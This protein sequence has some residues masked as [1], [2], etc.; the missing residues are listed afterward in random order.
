LSNNTPLN[1]LYEKIKKLNPEEILLCDI[2][3]FFIKQDKY[4][5]KDEIIKYYYLAINKSSRKCKGLLY[6][7]LG[8]Y[9]KSIKDY[10][11]MLYYFNRAFLYG[12]YYNS[13]E[14]CYFLY[15]DKCYEMFAKYIKQFDN[16][17][18]L[19]IKL[20]K[21]KYMI[22]KKQR[23]VLNEL[24]TFKTDILNMNLLLADYFRSLKDYENVYKCLKLAYL[25]FP[26][27]IKSIKNN[28]ESNLELL[29]EC[30]DIFKYMYEI[31]CH[32]MP[33]Y[34]LILSII[35]QLIIHGDSVITTEN[36]YVYKNKFIK[37]Y[38]NLRSKKINFY[39]MKDK[40]FEY[41]EIFNCTPQNGFL[42]DFLHKYLIS[43]SK[44]TYLLLENY[45][46]RLYYNTYQ[47]IKNKI[48]DPNFK[49]GLRLCFLS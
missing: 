33:T 30:P 45:Q 39:S 35:I 34:F 32:K 23:G 38:I 4:F 19:K 22:A 5:F 24:I 6:S 12:Y 18:C 31:E 42:Y 29:T 48:I 27:N 28:L 13:Y 9:F 25:Q 17:D 14:L 36:A 3:Q 7:T 47:I 15:K 2:A 46:F 40:L 1:L 8:F 11:N 21:F 44:E 43:Y 26:K 37:N 49:I 16:F 10:E 20:L 41:C